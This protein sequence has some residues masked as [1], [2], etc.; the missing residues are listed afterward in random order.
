MRRKIMAVLVAFALLFGT[1]APASAV[2]QSDG[3]SR[4]YGF[5]EGAYHYS[6][7]YH[8]LDCAPAGGG[9]NPQ[10]MWIEWHGKRLGWVGGTQIVRTG[11]HT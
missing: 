9:R 11:W 1:A 3:T 4:H 6:Y 5:W 10:C 7:A 8:T 2:T